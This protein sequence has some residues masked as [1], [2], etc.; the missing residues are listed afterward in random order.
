M[1]VLIDVGLG[2]QPVSWVGQVLAARDR[3]AAG[4]TASP[5]GLY[6]AD[7]RYGKPWSG[8]F[9]APLELQFPLLSEV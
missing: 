7:V 3:S 2:R 9:P 6:L 1:G 4:V 5:T 8:V